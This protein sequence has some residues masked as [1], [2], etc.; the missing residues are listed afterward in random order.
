MKSLYLI[1]T[2]PLV[3][4]PP[5]LKSGAATALVS[6]LSATNERASLWWRSA[7]GRCFKIEITPT[8]RN[9]CQADRMVGTGGGQRQ[10]PRAVRMAAAGG[11]R[12]NVCDLM[13][14][15]SKN[16]P[17]KCDRCAPLPASPRRQHFRQIAAG[18]S[19]FL[20]S[21]DPDPDASAERRT[22]AQC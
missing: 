20:R 16:A 22:Y 5:R 10:P 19:E 12:A 8:H 13:L 14:V 3:G 2:A 17:R 15:P 11:M 7:I 18:R 9:V 6:C 1:V 4:N 21:R